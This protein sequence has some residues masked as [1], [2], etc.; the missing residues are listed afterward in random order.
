MT[1]YLARRLLG[2]IPLLIGITFVSFFVIQLA[3]GSPVDVATDLN[4][5]A[6]AEVRERLQKTFGLDQPIHVQ[7]WRWLERIVRGDSP[8]CNVTINSVE[9]DL[10][11]I[12][13][14]LVKLALTPCGA[15]N[16]RSSRYLARARRDHE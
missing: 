4:P 7:Y 5:K 10:S 12:A 14:R 6:S 13:W 1:N 9:R 11:S 2:L 15:P 16:R 3:P 8:A